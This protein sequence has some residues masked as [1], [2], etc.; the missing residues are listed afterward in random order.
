VTRLCRELLHAIMH[1]FFAIFGTTAPVP[2]AAVLVSNPS[3]HGFGQRRSGNLW[4][5]VA[6][7]H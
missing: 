3:L 4:R 7:V 5:I 1:S 2:A 6:E